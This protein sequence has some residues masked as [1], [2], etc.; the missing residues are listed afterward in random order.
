MSGIDIKAALAGVPQLV[1][2]I[3]LTDAG[4]RTRTIA[5]VKRGTEAVVA[6]AEMRVPK[7]TGELAFTIR[8]EYGKD[9]MIGYAKAGYGTL[10]RRSQASTVNKADRLARRRG[11]S[12]QQRQALV[13]AAK[14]SRQAL[15]RVGGLGVYAPVVERGD[16]RRHHEPHPFLIPA[17]MAE[18]AGIMADI[19][20]AADDGA[21]SGGLG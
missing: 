14:S 5:A 13:N 8:A 21:A 12:A 9:G 3:Q 2:A 18:R 15:S 17:L 1:R 4:V 10:P 16:P 20:H 6:G 7:V 11:L 19:A